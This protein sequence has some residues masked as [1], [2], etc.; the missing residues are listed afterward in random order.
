MALVVRLA[1]MDADALDFWLGTWACAWDGGH[2]T[3]TVTREFDG[4]VVQETPAAIGRSSAS[5]NETP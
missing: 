5:K 2:G 4:R 1:L 3:N